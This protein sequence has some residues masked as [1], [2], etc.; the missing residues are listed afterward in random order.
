MR[1]FLKIYLTA[2]LCTGIQSCS[3]MGSIDDIQP[4]HVVDDDTVIVD[5]ETAEFALNGV[6]A[7]LRTFEIGTFRSCMSLWANSIASSSVAGAGEFKGDSQNR[8]SIKIENS[9]VEGL[10][11]G[12]YLVINTANSFIANLEKNSPSDLSGMRKA[13]MLGEARCMRA[14]FNLHLLRLFG[15][16]YDIDSPYGIVLYDT[17]VRDNTPRSRSKVYD[18][19]TM[20]FNDLDFAIRNAPDYQ[21]EHCRFSKTVAKALLARMYL[22]QNHY[23][24]AATTAGEVIEEAMMSGY[25]LEFDFLS[26]FSSQFYSSEMLFAPYVSQSSGETISSSWRNTIPGSLLTTLA[27]T[28]GENG[29]LEPRY[30]ATYVNVTNV[31]MTAKY[32]LFYNTTM[33]DNSYYFMRLPEVYYIKAEAEARLGNYDE[34]REAMRPLNDRAGYSTDYVD[35]IPDNKMLGTVLKNKLMELS[36]ESGEEWFDLVRYHREG[37]YESWNDDE[38]AQLPA[39]NQLLLPIPRTAMAGNK[40]LIQNPAYQSM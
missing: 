20:I 6:Y 7:S 38:K 36:V 33:D 34:A 24:E 30:E 12:C 11:R 14:M 39:F 40:L 27:S 18:C 25:D 1:T 35:N 9:A 31:N 2:I 22:S 28:M 23:S 37:G 13:E 21:F 4:E 19:Y 15:E 32:P 8:S 17:P 5:A 29:V 26:C 3:L 10:Y 16:Y